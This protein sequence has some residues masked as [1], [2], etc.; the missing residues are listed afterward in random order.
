MAKGKKCPQCGAYMQ[1]IKEDEQP[2]GT[3]VVYECLNGNCKFQE[4]VFESE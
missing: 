1:A 4:K 3:W 2:K